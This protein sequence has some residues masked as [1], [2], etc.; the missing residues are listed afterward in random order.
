M[1]GLYSLVNNHRKELVAG[2]LGEYIAARTLA[3]LIG[4]LSLIV[5]RPGVHES[6][7]RVGDD[8]VDF[9]ELKRT[10]SVKDSLSMASIL[11]EIIH[12]LPLVC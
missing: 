5:L 4:N 3:H 6:A 12:A 7:E 9:S 1:E 8:A 10:Y 11:R 2:N